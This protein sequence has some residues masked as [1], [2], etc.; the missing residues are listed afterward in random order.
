MRGTVNQAD[1]NPRMTT[2]SRREL[3]SLVAGLPL[4]G[5]MRSM[6]AG[7]PLVVG[8]T[9]SSFRDLPRV[10]GRD[11]L[12]AVIGAVRAAGA[13]HVELAFADLE[14]APP[15]T[16][17]VM[18][19]SAA[20]PRR[21]VLSP[22]EIAA[23][24]AGVRATLRTWRL[25]TAPDFFESARGKLAR[26]GLTVHGC[27]LTC[28][29]SWTDDEIDATFRHV[30]A[31]GVSVIGSPLTM[32]I[33]KRLV[34][35]AERHRIAIAIRNQPDGNRQGEI[36]TLR[37]E[38]ALALSPMFRVALD[39]GH[40]TASNRDAVAELRK[41]RSRV[42]YAIVK[43]RLRNGGASQPFGEGDTPLR[44][45]IEAPEGIRSIHSRTRRVRLRRSSFIGGGGRSVARVSE[46]MT[47]VRLGPFFFLFSS[48]PG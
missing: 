45:L 30:K 20:Y 25:Q 24:N 6:A 5:V 28:D 21:I 8:V 10:T 29:A 48:F 23:T 15:N 31:L 46:G 37:L 26:A 4:A 43:D 19:G 14:P 27:A 38:P 1:Y 22:A 13:S 18:G 2:L 40:L 34:S 32:A 11:N 16:G 36:D 44:G 33:A 12:D 41:C 47:R 7:D 42:A 17:P 9:T 39:V 3:G 35:F